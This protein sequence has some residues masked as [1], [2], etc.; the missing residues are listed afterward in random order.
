MRGYTNAAVPNEQ[1]SQGNKKAEEEADKE[2]QAKIV[3]IKEAGSQS[4]DKVVND[5]LRAVF[6]VKPVPPT[7]G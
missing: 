5:L 1:H 6:D 2:A 7:K 4:Q 3:E